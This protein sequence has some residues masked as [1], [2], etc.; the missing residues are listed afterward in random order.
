MQSSSFVRKRSFQGAAKQSEPQEMRA[1]EGSAA[2]EEASVYS[3]RSAK[4]LAGKQQEISIDIHVKHVRLKV[5]EK[6][7]V[8]IM[9]QRGKKQAKTQT[10]ILNASLDKAVFDEKFQIN[11]ILEFNEETN[12]P[13]REKLSKMVLLL[14]Q[15]YSSAENKSTT[16]RLVEIGEADLNMA[17]YSQDTYKAVKLMFRLKDGSPI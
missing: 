17:D 7:P 9:W 1:A 16:G 13:A 4:S 15:K 14:D 10:K 12:L 11:T 6:T 5:F 3:R 8:R 2:L